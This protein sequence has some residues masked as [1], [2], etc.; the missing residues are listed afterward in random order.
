MALRALDREDGAEFLQL[1]G[2][3]GIR[4]TT[5]SYPMAKAPVALADLAHGRFGGAAVLHN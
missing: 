4:S 1:A 5:V 3:W 2:E